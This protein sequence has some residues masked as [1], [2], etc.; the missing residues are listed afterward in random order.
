MK[1]VK[2]ILFVFTVLICGEAFKNVDHIFDSDEWWDC[3]NHG[4]DYSEDNS[5]VRQPFVG[6]ITRMRLSDRC[7]DECYSSKLDDRFHYSRR[8]VERLVNHRNPDLL[9]FNSFESQLKNPYLMHEGSTAK[10]EPL[11]VM[12]LVVC[13]EENNK[14]TDVYFKYGKSI[15]EFFG[16]DGIYRGEV[17]LDADKIVFFGN[18]DTYPQFGTYFTLKIYN[19]EGEQLQSIAFNYGRGVINELQTSDSLRDGIPYEY[20]YVLEIISCQKVLVRVDDDDN[21]GTST[22]LVS[23]HGPK[24]FGCGHKFILLDDKFLSYKFYEQKYLNLLLEWETNFSDWTKEM[25]KQRANF[26]TFSAHEK[27]T[28]VANKR[29]D[30]KGY[31]HSLRQDL[32]IIKNSENIHKLQIKVHRLEKKIDDKFAE[33]ERRIDGIQQQIDD[34]EANQCANI[35]GFISPIS[36]LIP[37]AGTIFSALTGVVAASCTL[38]G[39]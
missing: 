25:R 16:S 3:N 6:F 30:L 28:W 11:H 24:E 12:N 10:F 34:P 14:K 27:E 17:G 33:L 29:F 9:P 13:S 1:I 36:S 5:I 32:Q 22:Q 8:E 35:S 23:I 2:V 38:A 18:E 7:P 21:N 20:G 4:Y 31:I 15:I 19:Q 26:P 39:I 37:G